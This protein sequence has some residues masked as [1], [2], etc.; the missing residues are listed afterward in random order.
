MRRL[1]PARRARPACLGRHGF[2]PLLAYCDET[3]GALAGLLRPGT[4]LEHGC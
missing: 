2:H 1:I 3:G 4:R